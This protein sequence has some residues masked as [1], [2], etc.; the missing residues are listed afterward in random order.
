MAATGDVIITKTSANVQHL[1][2]KMLDINVDI[3]VLSVERAMNVTFTTI[4]KLI[5]DEASMTDILELL[6]VLN[7]NVTSL[8]MFG[9]T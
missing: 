3:P 1:K 7:A 8:H 4:N 9:D 5:I 6:P 2:R